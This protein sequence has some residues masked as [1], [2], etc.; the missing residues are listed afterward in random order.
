MI[1]NA[2]SYNFSSSYLPAELQSVDLS[3]VAGVRSTEDGTILTIN[4]DSRPAPRSTGGNRRN[5][6]HS[7][8]NLKCR[9]LTPAT[10]PMIKSTDWLARRT[11]LIGS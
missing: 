2:L 1:S 9:Q 11:T 10:I 4:H 3:W 5:G 7:N 8:I 6:E